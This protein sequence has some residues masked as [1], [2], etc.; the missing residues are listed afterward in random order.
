MNLSYFPD[1]IKLFDAKNIISQTLNSKKIN[2]SALRVIGMK[3]K[4]PTFFIGKL[5]VKL[6][7]ILWNGNGYLIKQVIRGIILLFILNNEK[8]S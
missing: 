5:L 6:L 3:K 1:D 8:S 7:I 2:I 4:K